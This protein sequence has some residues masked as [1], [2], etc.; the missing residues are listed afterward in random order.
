MS[1]RGNERESYLRRHRWVW[2]H[3]QLLHQSSAAF[4]NCIHPRH[5]TRGQRPCV[6]WKK[7]NTPERSVTT[8]YLLLVVTD[9]EEKSQ[10]GLLFFPKAAKKRRG[11][12][13]TPGRGKRKIFIYTSWQN[14]TIH[15][16]KKITS[17]EFSA[18]DAMGTADEEAVIGRRVRCHLMGHRLWISKVS[19]SD[20]HRR[21]ANVRGEE[22]PARDKT[23]FIWNTR[24]PRDSWEL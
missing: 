20:V 24:C 23:I 12:R 3:L 7:S 22:R 6:L 21:R 11:N 8:I 13:E 9:G 4:G 5:K 15:K 2:D 10:S 1:Q 19:C 18:W 16:Q 14:K 17:A